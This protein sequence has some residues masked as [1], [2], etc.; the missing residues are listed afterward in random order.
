MS[1][2]VGGGMQFQHSFMPWVFLCQVLS[3][4]LPV[5]TKVSTRDGP[6]IRRL[7][8]I[9]GRI[10]SIYGRISNPY[11]AWLIRVLSEKSDL[12]HQIRTKF[13]YKKPFFTLLSPLK[14]FLRNVMNNIERTQIGASISIDRIKL[15]PDPPII[16]FH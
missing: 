15:D 7:Y 10:Y 5:S 16:Y 4:G 3:R 8:S 13:L 9:S 14:Y 6:E 11:L 12:Y 2:V 1:G